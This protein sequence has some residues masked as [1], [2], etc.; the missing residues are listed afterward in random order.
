LQAA[1]ER[2]LRMI[3]DGKP[4]RDILSLLTATG[5][6]VT[7][8]DFFSDAR[9]AEL[10]HWPR[11]LGFLGAWSRPIKSAEGRVLGTF[12]THFREHRLPS[13]EERAAIA[14]LVAIAAS[15]IHRAAIASIQPP[16]DIS[17]RRC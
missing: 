12:G 14:F 16:T 17:S 4:L 6:V 13:D 2:A 1:Q 11:V 5:E 10:R 7:T 8:P 9:W 3:E 15:A